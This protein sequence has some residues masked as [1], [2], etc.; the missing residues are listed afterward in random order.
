MPRVCAD[1]VCGCSSRELRGHACRAFGASSLEDRPR[2]RLLMH[3]G[4][5]LNSSVRYDTI[6]TATRRRLPHTAATDSRGATFRR[7]AVTANGSGR[8]EPVVRVVCF[9][10]ALATPFQSSEFCVTS[11]SSQS[12]AAATRCTD[13]PESH[14][15]D[16]FE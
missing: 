14:E 11:V 12:L 9:V 6:G 4:C 16:V 7:R 3:S 8:S 10:L 2:Q 15:C 1:A 5:H 13:Y